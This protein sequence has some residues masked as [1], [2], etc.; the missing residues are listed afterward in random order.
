MRVTAG[1][2]PA[3]TIEKEPGSDPGENVCTAVYT[4]SACH[5]ELHGEQRLVR[6]EGVKRVGETA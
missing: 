1:R 4:S 3:A 6:A 5:L 2:C